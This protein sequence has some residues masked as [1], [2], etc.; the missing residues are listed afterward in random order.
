MSI[1]RTIA[2]NTVYN[3]AGR[4]WEA[5]AGIALTVYIIERVGLE[6]FGLWSLI[7]LFTGYAAL[8]DF[9]MS[10]AFS[11]FI[12]ACAARGD[13]SGV[14]GV[15]STGFYFYLA[16]GAGLLAIGWPAIDG[17]LQATVALAAWL[18]PGA[19]G[20]APDSAAREEARFLLRGALLLFVATNAMAPFSAVPAG[21]QRMGVSNAIGFGV[22]LV[23]ITATVAF[24][25]QGYG[26]RGLLY[27]SG[28]V[29]A[30]TAVAHVVAARLLY[31][32]LR[33]SPFA[34]RGALFQ[35]ML[36]FG[37]RAQVARLANL[38]NFQTDRMVVALV[39][40][41]ALDLVGL[42]RIG[43]DL[44]QKLRQIPALLVSALTPAASDLDARDDRERLAMLYT[45]STR[46]M[47]AVTVPLTLFGM[48]AADL[49]LCLYAAKADHGPAVWVARI[50]LAG[51]AVNVL[52]GPGVSIALG[53]GNAGLPMAAGLISTVGNIM[54]TVALYMAIGFYGIP[55]AT[56]IALALSS[57]WFFRAMRRE[58]D[59]PVMPL[60]RDALL[61]PVVAALPGTVFSVGV[62][63][64]L[65]DYASR[66]GNLAAALGC[67]V[68]FA[69]SYGLLLWRLPFFD[70]WD[71]A[72]FRE[73][74]RLDRFQSPIGEEDTAREP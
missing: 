2:H 69:A 14:S 41:G 18:N 60:L 1:K 70:A 31:P 30:A 50:L 71:R 32:G 67:G 4:C 9:G 54:L 55:A 27:A 25:E 40:G 47:A 46:Y 63:W 56:A 23:K 33:C 5:I 28:I 52:P 42:Y 53:K 12:A 65:A 8:F 24:L 72:F 39:G 49:L 29:L 57:A 37:W 7:A 15:V 35:S 34:M 45:R 38:V 59:A 13:R 21:L 20:L 58:V 68:V 74:L 6:G 17:L 16:L 19:P 61:G 64:V 51:Y 44:A 22:S 36:S 48:A 26:V 43:E 62:A 66:M 10:S 73:A 11:R 3:A